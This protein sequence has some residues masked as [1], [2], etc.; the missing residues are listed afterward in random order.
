MFGYLAAD[1]PA[2]LAID[3]EGELV[4]VREAG[5]Q[6]LLATVRE[7][8]NIHLVF[9]NEFMVDALDYRF[10]GSN[11]AA[12]AIIAEELGQLD[13]AQQQFSLA[14]DVLVHA[15]NTSVGGPQGTRIGDFFTDREYEIFGIVS[16]RFTET[17]AEQAVRYRQLSQDDQALALY[18][19]A[20]T[21]QYMQALAL[22]QRTVTPNDDTPE[23]DDDE[24]QFLDNGGWE[25]I[26][27]LQSLQAAA[28]S[29]RD[30][31]N[32]FGFEASYV[33]LQPYIELRQL[34]Q[35]DFLRDASEDENAAAIAQREFDQNRTA[36]TQELQN[37]RLTYNNNLLQL[38]GASNDNF[39]TCEGGVMEQNYFAM[40]T[41]SERLD[42]IAQKLEN[43]AA[44]VES[45]QL[46]AGQIISLTLE[47]GA[48]LAVDAYARGV[49][50][51]YRVTE[52]EVRT[53]NDEIYG[54]GEVRVGVS[55]RIG[56]PPKWGVDVNASVFAGYRHSESW[57]NS[58]TTIWDPSQLELAAIDSVQALREAARQAQITG[59]ESDARIRSLLLQQAEL[60]I[61]QEIA[62]IEWNRLSAEHNHLVQQYHN[63]LNLREQ[64][65]E[66]LVDSYLSNPAYRVLR[67]SLTVEAS[68]S[69]EL[70]AQFAYL[71][72]KALEYEFLTPIDFLGDIFKARTADDI[73]NYLNR[74]EVLRRSIG[75]PGERNRFPHR[76]S[77]A[78]D[79][80]GF[81]DEVL[82]PDGV[83]SP[84]QIANLRFARFQETLQQ[85]VI[86]D[87]QSGQV[88]GMEL[89]FGTS[90]EDGRIFSANV[91]NN[92]IAGVGQP[93]EVPGTVGIA[94]NLLTRQ[95]ADLGTPEVIL[96]HA[97]HSSY[98]TLSG[99]IIQYTPENARPSGYP[100]PGGFQSRTKTAVIL[101]SVN[102]FG[103]PTLSSALFNR[104]VA[105]SGWRLRID[106]NS[107]FNDELDLNQVEDIEILMDT[108]AIAIPQLQLQAEEEAEQ[109]QREFD[110]TM[111][112]R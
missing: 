85:N 6:A 42:L 17:V 26:H 97:G 77:L 19:D 99:E 43:L 8:A 52:A 46:R 14:V 39:A 92:R 86:T 35:G 111:S 33:P 100:V 58:T 103:S 61:E 89:P 22:A 106:L 112:E 59:I 94:I 57:T 47:N 105:A 51:A 102:G 83:L 64:A 90:L 21:E 2:D 49:I 66:D 11:P 91:W 25:F 79:V 16:D 40:E 107:P 7:L 80:L 55:N 95:F 27:N 78:Q 18:A 84:F 31:V 63:W 56:V 60:M 81:T 54:G 3:V 76:I 98:R 71:T 72:A 9:G 73:D 20:F 29:V 48:Q 24:G 37:L 53:R 108:T 10:G 38:C 87:T 62:Y 23:N 36:L 50:S 109:L 110:P 69:L 15:F 67:D 82:D 5:R 88:I 4:N 96:T 34:T 93:P 30:G 65:Q 101:A 41:A 104:S 1:A 13:L 44:E 12:D 75:S 68:R 45:E 32:P 28:Q 70:A 74:L